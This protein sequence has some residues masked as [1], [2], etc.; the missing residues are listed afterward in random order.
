MPVGFTW[1]TAVLP[2]IRYANYP[3]SLYLNMYFNFVAVGGFR[4]TALKRKKTPTRLF[5][6]I[7]RLPKNPV[8]LYLERETRLELATPTLARSC[9]TN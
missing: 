5:S 8:N 3:E 7:Y 4:Q 9:S 6:M 2:S 1:R